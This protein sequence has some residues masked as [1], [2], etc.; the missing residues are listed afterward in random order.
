MGTE[1]V[2]K[3]TM[4]GVTVIDATLRTTQT[5]VSVYDSS[6]SEI[7]I[8]MAKL[9]KDLQRYENLV[10][11]KLEATKRQ[12]KAALF[13]VNDVSHRRENVE[14]GIQCA[15]AASEMA[16]LNLSYTVVVAPCDGKLG[17]RVLEE[18]QYNTAG[19]TIT[20]ILPDTQKWLIANYKET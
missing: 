12:R 5:T 8:P 1:A 14:T 11:R 13:G 10:Q 4:V 20:Y 7:E 19:Q 3:D 18:G 9:E 16:R 6:I 15:T 17:R 2:L